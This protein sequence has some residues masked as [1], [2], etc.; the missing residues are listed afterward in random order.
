M[1]PEVIVD[2]PGNL[3][4][5]FEERVEGLAATARNARGRFALALPGGSVARQFLPDL[6]QASVDW[7]RGRCRP[8]IP[9]RTMDWPR[10]RGS[11]TL[12]CLPR[13]SIACPLTPRT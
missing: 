5:I 10:P 4:G 2:K 7:T 13:A 1:A 6:G 12:A 8:R 11:R 9:S 3:P